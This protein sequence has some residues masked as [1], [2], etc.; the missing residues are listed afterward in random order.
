[1]RILFFAPHADIWAHAFPEALIAEALVQAGHEIIYVTCG[2]QFQRHCVAMS[3]NG[4]APTDSHTARARVCAQCNAKDS[5]LRSEF[6]FTGPKIADLITPEDES[7][8]TK[9][10]QDVTREHIQTLEV[11]G[12]QVGRLALYQIMLRHKRINLDL[13]EHEWS[14]Y[15]VELRNTLYAAF[16]GRKLL[17]IYRPDRVLV[18]NGLYAVNRVVCK[19][20]ERRD[21]PSYF[22]HAGGNLSNRLQTLMLG[23]GDTFRFMPH[24]VSQW[25][26]YSNVPC[27]AKLLS[28]VT[29]HYIELLRGRSVFVYS[30]AV[31]RKTFDVRARFGV[32]KN[33]KL[34]VATMGSYDEEVAA[35]MVGARK[36]R[37]E[38]LFSTQVEWI[39]ALISFVSNRPYLYLIVRVH[40]RE[41]PNKREGKLSQ[42]A[43]LLMQ[44]LNDVP[45]NVAINWP[46]DGISMYDLADQTDV[47]LNSWSSVGKEMSLLGIPVVIYSSELVFYPAELNYLGSS[48]E[49]YFNVIEQ[50]IKDGWSFERSRMAYRW[51]AVEYGHSLL[52]L[53]DS[54]HAVEYSDRSLSRKITDRVRRYIDP[55]FVERSDCR[56]RK[57]SLNVAAI[58]DTLIEEK[59]E[60]ILDFLEVNSIATTDFDDETTALSLEL[61][62]I[63]RALY[64]DAISR[65]RSRLYQSLTGKF[66]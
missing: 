33:Q 46:S 7:V 64:P 31:S 9:I 43:K 28:L 23:R 63:G 24:L 15:L 66:R 57:A 3:A 49:E 39:Q 65:S 10:M 37:V 5:L 4:M 32:E 50:A 62:R 19:I 41:F 6:K 56:L 48:W 60:S 58:V 34:L 26:R 52:F 12:I 20:A 14:D 53:D 61:A 42:H 22:M 40:P 1:M 21:I 8:V 47:F 36:H 35:E 16:A 44:V 51:G 11:E 54:Y 25:P 29:D 17:D 2:S 59:H 18:Y 45:M 38:P 30:T 27:S 13:S 55:I